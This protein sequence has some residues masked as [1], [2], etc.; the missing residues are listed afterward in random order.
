M[1]DSTTP[2]L[3]D[4]SATL[5]DI[6]LDDLTEGEV[7]D[8]ASRLAAVT[9]IQARVKELND[10]LQTQLGDLFRGDEMPLQ[11]V[12]TLRRQPYQRDRWRDD[13]AKDALNDR[14]ALEVANR[15]GRDRYTGEIDDTKRD[16][17]FDAVRELLGAIY[18]P[19]KLKVAGSKSLGIDI[20]DYRIVEWVNR[21]VVD[22]TQESSI[23]S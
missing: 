9:R 19:S 1:E 20:E 17:A 15:I 13:G 7:Y 11:G 21:Y 18:Q 22:P 16:A 23:S 4:V 6:V 10:A 8:L 14:L 5:D 3:T 12:G 2:L